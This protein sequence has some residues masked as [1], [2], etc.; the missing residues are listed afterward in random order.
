MRIVKM[1]CRPL[2][3]LALTGSLC[4]TAQENIELPSKG[5]TVYVPVYS[6]IHHG[7]LDSSGKADYDLMSV[8]VSVRN[9]DPKEGIRI[10]SAPYYDTNGKLIRDYLAKPR[11]IPPFG[12][13]E[14]F[15]ERKEMQGGSGASFVIRWEAEK[16][17]KV[18]NPPIV[19]A[20]HTRFQAGRTMGFISRGKAIS[21]P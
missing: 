15:V 20:L 17:D 5:Q 16:P 3:L 8:L 7:N 13:F 12:T 2:L 10:V 11:V 14:L 1:L 21:A 9:T 19:E 6:A 18:V 4:A